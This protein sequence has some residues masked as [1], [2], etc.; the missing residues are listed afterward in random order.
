MRR[1]AAVFTGRRADK[2]DAGSSASNTERSDRPQGADAFKASTPSAKSRAGFFRS[3]SKSSLSQGRKHSMPPVSTMP[4][5][6]GSSASSSSGG[7]RTP[8]D[9][10]ESLVPSQHGHGRRSWL[11]QVSDMHLPLP[12]VP[13]KPTS[14]PY[15]PQY[16]SNR[17]SD[18]TSETSS[19]SGDGCD[20]DPRRTT[21]VGMPGPSRP[22][23]PAE[24]FH[25]VTAN[26]L[27]PPFSPPPLLELRNE[28]SYPRS[29]NFSRQLRPADS[30]QA[31]VQRKQLLGRPDLS[32]G[33]ALAGFANRT[34]MPQTHSLVLDDVAIPKTARVQ[35]F[36]QGLRRWTERPCFEDRVTV[37]FPPEQSGGELR[38]ERVYASAAVEALAISEQTEA[39]AG[40]YDDLNL[41]VV[42]PVPSSSV[43]STPQ[44]SMTPSSPS[45]LSSMPP[46]PAL[47]P[48]NSSLAPPAPKGTN[49]LYKTTPS[50]LRI[51][52]TD[53]IPEA[54]SPPAAAPKPVVVPT[55]MPS[56]PVPEPR[57]SSIS[58][59]SPAVSPRPAVRFAE[60]EK[61]DSI[62]LEYV[63]RKK[64][65]RDKK[66][67]FLA[68]ESA[69][70]LSTQER[71]ISPRFVP[72]TSREDARRLAEERK[73]VEEERRQLEEERKKWERER[74]AR[75][76]AAEEQNRKQT[77]AEGFTEARR[78]QE[79]T[80]SGAVPKMGA[81]VSWEGDRER[82]RERKTSETK[83]AY[84]R[85][86][87]DSAHSHSRP[88]P[89]LPQRQ[90]SE[91]SVH[92]GASSGGSP[93]LSVPYPESSPGSSRPPSIAAGS[94]RGSSRPPS[95]YS[96]PPSS[97]SA[98]DV[99]QR[100][101]SK[102]SRR[103]VIS[104][105]GSYSPSMY[106][107]PGQPGFPWGV[108]LMPAMPVGMNMNMNMM[109][110][111]MP[112][113]QMPVMPY[114]DMP[115]LPPTPPFMLQ[116][117]GP[118]HG[119][120]QRSHSSSP[121]RGPGAE[122]NKRHSEPRTNHRRTP[123]DD[124]SGRGRT[125]SPSNAPPP[126]S[127]SSNRSLRTHAPPVHSQS[128]PSNSNMAPPV[129]S[130]RPSQPAFQNLSRPSGNR[131]QTMIT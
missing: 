2:S 62:P 39:L 63:L 81:G 124:V 87:Y 83:S 79:K 43:A 75:E 70:R 110:V 35:P 38:S 117:Y 106:S 22:M 28:P 77:Y 5:H 36:S 21:P 48:P 17:Q 23:V 114:T 61:D 112:M 82:E 14:R 100:R 64:Q 59:S 86:R 85:P 10:Q 33:V 107:P 80:R 47:S 113:M 128:S 55:K 95:M 46:S 109:P 102:A 119:A 93:R 16:L 56:P 127:S 7:P 53:T 129:L 37:Y 1:L 111:G 32:H 54:S 125:A 126:P 15:L 67:R 4:D 26:A 8:S 9:D 19:E 45:S 24:Y 30:L 25:A 3:L 74:A 78:R 34:R 101:E 68:A 11:P 104:D 12:P 57:P 90:S 6:V 94:N 58:P 69:R 51:E 91:P 96:T 122:S 42:S 52:S 60:E 97:A 120:G 20:Q 88:S 50:P 115:L 130:S 18:P 66:A 40:L 65:A 29:C 31:R 116:Q 121:T 103:S 123:S 13:P 41:P 131:R 108:P 98:I 118:R 71:A 92:L 105:G 84:S 72:D 73:R 27:L 89:P 44:F 99:R 49:A 76:R